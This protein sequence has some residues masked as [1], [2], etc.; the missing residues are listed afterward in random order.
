M[1][2]RVNNSPIP[3]PSAVEAG[4]GSA[5]GVGV[6]KLEFSAEHSGPE[7]ERGGRRERKRKAFLWHQ[8]R[9]S[10]ALLIAPMLLSLALV[11]AYPLVTVLWLSLR[12]RM[13]IFGIDE[14][15]G[16]DNYA[17]MF[18]DLRFWNAL[19]NT[20]YFT[21]VS[22]F[23]ELLLGLAFAL[24][25]NR[26]FKGRGLVRAVILVPWAIPTVV[27]ARLWQWLLTPEYGLINHLLNMPSLNWLG[28]PALAIHAAIVADVWKSTPFVALLLLAGL[29]TIPK[30]LYQAAQIDGAS[31]WTQF[32]EIT[33]PLLAPVMGVT[34]LFRSL[35]AFR[36]FDVIFVLTGGGPANSTETLSVYAYR[37][38]FSTLQFGYGSAVS[39]A[40]FVGVL[41]ISLLFLTVMGSGRRKEAGG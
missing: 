38:L 36:V 1:T 37:L 14:W 40:T 22:V 10:A 11:A 24:A 2:K 16:L 3:S 13:L 20:V 4:E 15:V 35:D 23:F 33:L 12:R 26:S 7:T 21:G 8:E 34:L 18:Q 19:W 32:R 27:S 29:Q 39:V 41:L 9:F 5:P 31:R 17:F 25:V 6:A 30:E 28:S